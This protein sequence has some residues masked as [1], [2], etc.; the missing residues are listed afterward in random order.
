[1]PSKMLFSFQ[2]IIQLITQLKNPPCTGGNFKRIVES[3]KQSAPGRVET[4]VFY[5][6]IKCVC[7]CVRCNSDSEE[8]HLTDS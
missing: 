3:S 8:H 1:M 5:A 7:T 6:G 2:L 4:G